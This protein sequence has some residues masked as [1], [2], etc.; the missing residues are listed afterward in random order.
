L[1]GDQLDEVNQTYDDNA[2]TVEVWS[3]PVDPLT[4]PV[5]LAEYKVAREK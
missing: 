5:L 4:D 2:V 1:T 3:A